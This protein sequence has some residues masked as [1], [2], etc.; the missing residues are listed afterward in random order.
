MGN[1]YSLEFESKKKLFLSDTN[2]RMQ[3]CNDKK[4]KKD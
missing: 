4:G 3:K 1:C 2:I